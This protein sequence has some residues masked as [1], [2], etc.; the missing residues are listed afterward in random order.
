MNQLSNELFDDDEKAVIVEQPEGKL[1]P[2]SD[3]DINHYLPED[4]DKKALI[5]YY[6]E[7]ED[8]EIVVNAVYAPY[9]IR[10]NEVSYDP[11]DENPLVVY[12][13]ENGSIDYTESNKDE[14]GIRP[15]MYV[16]TKKAKDLMAKRLKNVF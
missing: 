5:Y 6:D 1:F 9:W 8:G 7:P 16:D 14:I 13:T 15:A 4:E 11:T 10:Q 12:V 2:L 3:I